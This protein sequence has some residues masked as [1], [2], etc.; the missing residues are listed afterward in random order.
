[1]AL[2]ENVHESYNITIMRRMM[3]RIATKLCEKRDAL[4]IVNGDLTLYE[5]G[6]LSVEMISKDAV[7][8]AGDEVVT[9]YISDKYLPGL[10]IG[11]ITEV[12]MDNDKLSQTAKITPRVSFD[13]IT[14][15]M[16]ITQL[17]S[18]MI[19]SEPELEE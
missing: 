19:S 8:T 1:M 10:V 14:N 16:I 17:K 4:C 7:V 18:D 2:L 11:Y 13:N 9:S 3:Y 12:S 15:V 6:Q 5:D